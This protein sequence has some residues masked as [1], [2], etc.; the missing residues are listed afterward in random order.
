MPA[1][2]HG[3]TKQ[4][5]SQSTFA[6]IVRYPPEPHSRCKI[7]DDRHSPM[8]VFTPYRHISL[9]T[10]EALFTHEDAMVPVLQ[11]LEESQ[12]ALPLREIRELTANRMNIDAATRQ[13]MLPSGTQSTYNNRIGWAVTFLKKAGLLK[14]PKRAFYEITDAGR[15]VVRSG[16]AS[17]DSRWLKTH[18]SAFAQWCREVNQ[19]HRRSQGNDA[20]GENDPSDTDSELR[21][22][23]EEAIEQA[24][25]ALKANLAD[26][27]LQAILDKE[28]VFFERLV[29][30]LLVKMGYGGSFEDA[31]RSVGQSGDGGIDG[32]IKEDRLGLDAI[33]IQ[34][35]RYQG[36]VG[37]PAVQA[38]VGAITGHRSSKGVFLTTG[39]FSREA[40]D[41]T[42]MLDKSVVL[43]DGERLASLM[44]EYGLGVTL[45]RSYEVK[46]LDSDFFEN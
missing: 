37:R 3:F 15:E 14:Q 5:A 16:V 2:A 19:S 35:K 25:S 38:F 26:E 7:S 42:T 28:P 9:R 33:Y 29:V 36:T 21:Q 46:R 4:V 6:R 12:A 10:N 31:A 24:H 44:I 43:I 32:I 13:V 20:Q 27:L 1:N 34:A 23:P 41:Y 45:E 18:S 39:S 22:T 8:Q 40:M 17:I 30:Q 11:L